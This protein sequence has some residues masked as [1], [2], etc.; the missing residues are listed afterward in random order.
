LEGFRR[1]E[2]ALDEQNTETEK[3]VKKEMVRT[4]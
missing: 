4:P 3:E 1:G 2:L